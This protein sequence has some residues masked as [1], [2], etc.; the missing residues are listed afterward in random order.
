[1]AKSQTDG[2]AEL[3]A[4]GITD[5]PVYTIKQSAKG[6]VYTY[7]VQ[8]RFEDSRGTGSRVEG[9]TCNYSFTKK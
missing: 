3:T 2:A 5:D 4:N 9:R 7:R 6:T 1:M 8:A